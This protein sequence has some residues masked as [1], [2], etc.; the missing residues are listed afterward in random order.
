MNFLG[1]L[2]S[3][4]FSIRLCPLQNK[5]NIYLH[6]ICQ[7]SAF[8]TMKTSYLKGIL[9]F[10]PSNYFSVYFEIKVV[11]YNLFEEIGTV[12]LEQTNQVLIQLILCHFVYTS[13]AYV[14]V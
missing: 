9:M 6:S 12:L 8:L 1:D 7:K 10:G 11:H 3:I 13:K 14:I 4:F 2:F 5:R